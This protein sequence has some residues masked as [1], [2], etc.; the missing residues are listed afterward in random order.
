MLW[1]TIKQKKTGVS[2]LILTFAL[3]LSACAP[4]SVA[5]VVPSQTP[6]V[7]LPE[8]SAPPQ[9][10]DTIEISEMMAKNRTTVDDGSA[11]FP[12][13]IELH[14]AGDESVDLDG[15][16]LSDRENLPKAKFPPLVLE[17]DEYL[18]IFAGKDHAPAPDE[19]LAPFGISAGEAVY[20]RAPDGEL[21]AA[22]ETGDAGADV[23]MIRS[24]EGEYHACAWPTPGFANTRAGFE[25]FQASRESASP[26]KINEVL[27]RNESFLP[28]YHYGTDDI[29]ELKNV[30]NAE[31]WL[32]DYAL[33]DSNTGMRCALPDA[34]L[35][36]GELFLIFC[37]GEERAYEEDRFYAPIALNSYEE[38]LYL[39]Y[40]S[41]I[42]ERF[43]SF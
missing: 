24:G 41:Q 22:A 36:P 26:L 29:V 33:S 8:E 9:Y 27:V 28:S 16:T 1:Q 31:I 3:L 39:S 40:S 35:R 25:D 38:Q 6:A 11:C 18:L 43:L 5:P 21:K 30:S 12:D 14:N 20:L 32:G 7:E 19:L 4:Q 34:M 10:P 2:A 23:S 37:C 17:P 42:K 15:W 13:W